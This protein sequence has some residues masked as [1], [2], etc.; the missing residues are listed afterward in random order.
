MKMRKRMIENQNGFK[1]SKCDLRVHSVSSSQN[2][3]GAI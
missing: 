3:K 1:F 2:R